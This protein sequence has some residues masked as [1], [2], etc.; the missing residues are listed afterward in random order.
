MSSIAKHNFL[1]K[2]LHNVAFNPWL[3]LTALSNIETRFFHKDL[4]RIKIKRPV[5]ITALPRA[6][7]T[8][9][10]QLCVKTNKFASHTYGDM[11]FL[12]T[13]LFWRSLSKAFRKLDAPQERVHGDGVMIDANSPESFEEIIWKKFWPSRYRSDRIIPWSEPSYPAFE[14]F[15]DEHARKIVFVRTGS[16]HLTSRYISKNNLNIARIKYLRSVF[17]DAIIIV[18]FRQ[19]LQHAASLL[20]Q[21]RN[22]LNIHENNPF[23][24]KYM[25]DTGHYDFGKNL[26]PINF[27]DWLS[28][29]NRAKPNNLLFWLQYWIKAY[30]YLLNNAKNEVFFLSY[31]RLCE[32]PERSLNWLSK[33]LKIEDA[34]TLT[35]NSDQI[36]APKSYSVDTTSINSETLHQAEVL[37]LDLKNSCE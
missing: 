23:A 24:R 3:P 18:P 30:Q 5:F 17:P 19:P 37:F 33:L 13:P 8:L 21:H 31:D 32:E 34:E 12:L 28:S 14:Q 29:K 27:N 7:T 36:F 1:D 4:S 22:F 6:G 35:K 11:P 2:A 9:L 25:K 16:E 26:R 15:F 20:R 10:L